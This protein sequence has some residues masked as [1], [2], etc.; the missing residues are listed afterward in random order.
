MKNFLII[1]SLFIFLVVPINAFSQKDSTTI[2]QDSTGEALIK[3]PVCSYKNNSKNIYCQVCGILLNSEEKK[4]SSKSILSAQNILKNDTVYKKGEK[5]IGFKIYAP[6]EK[7]VFMQYGNPLPWTYGFGGSISFEKLNERRMGWG[8]EV[9]YYLTSN[10]VIVAVYDSATEKIL[11]YVNA[12]YGYYGMK[13]NTYYKWK[14]MRMPFWVSAGLPVWVGDCFVNIEELRTYEEL[15][16]VGIGGDVSVGADIN[17]K[18]KVFLS[19]ELK[20]Q[21][22][23]SF[24]SEEGKFHRT[25]LLSIQMLL[26]LNFKF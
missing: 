19:P 17:P 16:L 11:G 15:F 13:A 1:P 6:M 4:D 7:E 22:I 25:F 12:E 21:L 20:V 24:F 14:G 5:Y 26:G 8:S 23:P 10:S 9:G 3:C 2:L 18:N